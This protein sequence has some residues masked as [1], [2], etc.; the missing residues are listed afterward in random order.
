VYLAC[1]F[2]A[3]LFIALACYS[4]WV[5]SSEPILEPIYVQVNQNLLSNAESSD[6]TENVTV[7]STKELIGILYQNENKTVIIMPCD[8][9]VIDEAGNVYHLKGPF[10]L[11]CG[12]I[13]L[14]N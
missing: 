6:T 2:A 10:E 3:S 1:S 7:P 13:Q 5:S 14:H 4:L 9:S 12:D 11:Q 8:G